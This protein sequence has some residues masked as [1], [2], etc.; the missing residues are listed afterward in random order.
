MSIEIRSARQ[1]IPGPIVALGREGKA[2]A[3]G[4]AVC[5]VP[6]G[7]WVHVKIAYD[8]AAEERPSTYEL[9]VTLPDGE[10]HQA[11]GTSPAPKYHRT[12]WL[13]VYGHGTQPATFYLDNLELAAV[14]ADGS[15]RTALRLDFEGG[16]EALQERTTLL[17]A[18]AEVAKRHAPPPVAV[19]ATEQ[20]RVGAYQRG[21]DRLLVHLH[22]REGLRGD[23]QQDGG[24]AATLRCAFAV[25]SARLALN[26]EAL[27]VR[28]REGRS[29]IA[30]PSVGLYQVI[31][32]QR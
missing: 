1:P 18:L 27:E 30:I 15:R 22:N 12:E 23:W 8:F 13:V 11:G 26:G 21:D 20:V 7:E 17:K 5:D 10:T 25:K 9:T 19:D 14:R 6:F 28:R 31:E 16:P 3:G 29:E 32:I 2:W 24:P 4:S